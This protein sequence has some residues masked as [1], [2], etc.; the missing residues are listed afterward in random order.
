MIEFSFKKVISPKFGQISKPVIPLTIIGP[1]RKIKVF[2]LLDSGA[3]I[4]M[5]PYSAGEILD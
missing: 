2:T 4:S 5:I 1:K 3:D